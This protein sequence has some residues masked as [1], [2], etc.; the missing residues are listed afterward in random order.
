[1]SDSH[2]YHV[3]FV[4]RQ[5]KESAFCDVVLMVVSHTH[6]VVY[7]CGAIP[8]WCCN[9]VVLYPCGGTPFCACYREECEQAQSPTTMFVQCDAQVQS[10]LSYTL[11][12]RSCNDG[13]LTT[14]ICKH[15]RMVRIAL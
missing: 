4:S 13:Q 10:I 3:V 12:P 11:L 6:V 15:G 14:D 9:L 7:P 2:V 1:M 5:V 8:L